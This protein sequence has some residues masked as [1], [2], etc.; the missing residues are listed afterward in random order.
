MGAWGSA[1]HPHIK[2]QAQAQAT[3]RLGPVRVLGA[4]LVRL[5][6]DA[7]G[8]VREDDG[9]LD[10]VLVLTAGAGASLEPDLAAG[11]QVGRADACGMS[12]QLRAPSLRRIG[13]RRLPNAAAGEPTIP[14]TILAGKPRPG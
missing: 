3:K 8:A 1:R 5:G 2:G 6:P 11:H 13:P 12:G 7:C 9:S 4:G 10:L 14:G